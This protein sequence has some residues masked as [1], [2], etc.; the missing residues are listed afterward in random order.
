MVQCGPT[1]AVVRAAQL[2]AMME[3]PAIPQTLAP[4]PA[5]LRILLVEDDAATL[6]GMSLLLGRAGHKVTTAHSIAVALDAA[7]GA[8]F[9]WIISDLGL[10][11]GRGTELMSRLLAKAGANGA[12]IQGIALTGSADLADIEE[13][14]R[15]GFTTHLAKP[16]DIERLE[17]ILAGSR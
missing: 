5:G 8:D 9:D 14:R 10:P 7:A 13:C 11:D 15:A 16:V 3:T 4:A 2:K 12:A 17:A 6:R 1:K